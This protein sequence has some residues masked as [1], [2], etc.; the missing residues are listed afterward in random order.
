MDHTTEQVITW[1]MHPLTRIVF[2]S[3]FASIALFAS[4]IIAWVKIVHPHVEAGIVAKANLHVA[5]HSRDLALLRQSHVDLRGD[6]G[7]IKLSV[8][9]M[10]ERVTE[11]GQMIAGL[12]TSFEQFKH[13]LSQNGARR[14]KPAHHK[15]P[16]KRAAK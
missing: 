7:E 15:T 5:E 6:L 13:S 14:P 3:V 1:L 4:L 9:N 2:G 16:A 10:T 8:S 11:Q 12:T